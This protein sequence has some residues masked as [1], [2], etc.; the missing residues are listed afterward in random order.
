MKKSIK[1]AALACAAL[2]LAGGP[3]LAKD[4]LLGGSAD[5]VV[6]ADKDLA[7]VKGSGSTTQLYTYYGAYYG[8]YASLYGAYGQYYN[9]Y[10]GTGSSSNAAS[11]LYYAQYYAYYSYYYYNAAYASALNGT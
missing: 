7:N 10:Q 2:A 6:M 1:Q 8:S 9:Y 11:N 5:A 3:S 4:P